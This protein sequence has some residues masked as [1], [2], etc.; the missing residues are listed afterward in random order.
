MMASG[1]LNGI[2]VLEFAGIGPGP[3]A[4]MMLSDM[5]ADVLR[6]ERKGTPDPAAE[7]IDARGRRT[8]ELDLKQSHAIDLCLKLSESAEIVFEGHRPGVM[9]RLGLGPRAMLARN[10]RLVYGRMT[11]WGQSGPYASNAGHDINYLSLSGALHAIGTEEKPVPPLNLAADYGGGAMFLIAGVLAAVIH[12]RA[13]GEGQVVDAAMTDGAAYL[14]TLFY[15]MHA[16]GTWEDRRRTNLL[17]GGAPFY[18]TYR[19]ADGKWI[20]VG[21]LEP[22][23]YALLLQKTGAAGRLA[24]PQMERKSWPDMQ[25][26]LRELFA[27]RTRQQWCDVL[28]NTDACFAPVL[29]LSEAPAHP[30]NRARG[31]F[32]ELAGVIQP[33]PAPRFSATPSRIQWPPAPVNRGAWQV[34]EDW[35]VGDE[36]LA[37]LSG[38]P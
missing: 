2:K 27:T 37:K 10:P 15:G 4:G 24:P 30:H 6:I 8:I 14:M 34:L 21:A 25:Q 29:S 7:R 16:A 5:G 17:D 36:D 28:E 35:G 33:A 23:F 11:G 31:T 22:Q 20:S 13:T 19:C 12:A 26:A 38:D 3:F 32:V 1:P 18:D 9:E